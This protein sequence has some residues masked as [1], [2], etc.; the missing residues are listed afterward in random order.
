[1]IAW[2]HFGTAALPTDGVASKQPSSR[3]AQKS[4]GPKISAADGKAVG[5]GWEPAFVPYRGR[6]SA[7][8]RDNSRS[9][10]HAVATLNWCP[11]RAMNV[12]QP[13]PLRRRSSDAR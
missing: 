12:I 4:T 6:G 8:L 5:R 11:H 13:R 10:Q 3:K 1:V 9:G 2:P 7:F